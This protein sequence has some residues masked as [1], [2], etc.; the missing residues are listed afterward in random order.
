MLSMYWYCTV[1]ALQYVKITWN[2]ARIE[3][4]EIALWGYQ[5]LCTGSRKI[6]RC[7]KRSAPLPHTYARQ[8]AAIPHGHCRPSWKL[9]QHPLCVYVCARACVCVCVCV[10][11]CA[12]ACT[13][14]CAHVFFHVCAWVCVCVCV[15]MQRAC[16]MCTYVHIHVCVH[17]CMSTC[18]CMCV[19]VITIITNEKINA[20]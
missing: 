10:C 2:I 9:L 6:W 4:K 13:C 14:V 12:C 20:C 8:S 16:M 18:A 1:V 7:P 15:C 19:H 17:M 11:G 3:M 5:L